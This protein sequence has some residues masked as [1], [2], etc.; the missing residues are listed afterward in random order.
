MCRECIRV[1]P[2][3]PTAEAALPLEQSQAQSESED[4]ERVGL[5]RRADYFVFSVEGTGST[6]VRTIPTEVR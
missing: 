5:G 2:A 6:A 4:G 3:L 1:T